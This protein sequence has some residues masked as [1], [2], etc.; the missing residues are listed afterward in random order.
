MF[1]G[2]LKAVALHIL[3]SIINA[4]SLQSSWHITRKNGKGAAILSS[5]KCDA[6]QKRDLSFL[7]P[8]FS[9]TP[10]TKRKAKLSD[11]IVPDSISFHML[12]IKTDDLL[13]IESRT[14]ILIMGK[15]L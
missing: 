11:F 10:K 14:Q 3:D 7:K 2:P 12:I 15:I 5:E 1:N 6:L 4:K 9:N 13:K 8:M